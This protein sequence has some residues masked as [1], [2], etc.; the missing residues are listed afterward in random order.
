[1]SRILVL[2]GVVALMMSS[3][4]AQTPS[5]PNA[6]PAAADATQ[7]IP[8]QGHDDLLVSKLKGTAVFGTEGQ[9]IGEIG[10]VLIDKMGHVKAYVVNVGGFLGIGAKQVALE[11][12]TFEEMAATQARP[13]LPTF[14]M[15]MKVPFTKDQVKQMASFRP[16]APEPSTTGLAPPAASTPRPAPSD[17]K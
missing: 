14:F 16:F 12:S 17:N 3:A 1:M 7:A 8:A 2:A 13:D 11:P 9:K 6:V 4:I 15:Q 5:A 10:D